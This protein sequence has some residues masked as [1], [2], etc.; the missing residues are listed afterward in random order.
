MKSKILLI[1]FSLLVSTAL[2]KAKLP[3]EEVLSIFHQANEQFRQANAAQDPQQAERYYESA[4]LIY[5]RII[6]EGQLENAKLYY[7]LANAYFLQGQLGKAILNYR[8]AEK[9]D[10]ADEN[11]QKNFA[12][13]RSRRID[14]I[15]VKTEKRVLKTLFFWHY[16]FSLKNRFLL[17]CIF[18]G[19]VCLCI[20]AII[21]FGKNISWTISAIICSILMLCFLTSVALEYKTQVNKVCGVITAKEV[22]AHQG[23]G[24]NYASS[25]KEPL[26]EGTEFDLLE[27]RQGWFHIKLFDDS[28]GWIP[29]NAAELI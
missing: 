5:E 16:D 19:I 12:F 2:A 8:R 13:A 22:I 23:D 7:N 26:H 15:A 29:S 10:D 24:D 14:K 6:D 25:F 27:N 20:T 18:F 17:T 4:I 1:A 3:A 9:I 28:D 11:I 21:S